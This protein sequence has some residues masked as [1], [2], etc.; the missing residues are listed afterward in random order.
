MAWFHQPRAQILRFY[1]LCLVHLLTQNLVWAYQKFLSIRNFSTILKMFLVYSKVGFYYIN[2]T[3]WVYLK[4]FDYTLKLVYNFKDW[5]CILKANFGSGDKL[6]IRRHASVLCGYYLTNIWALFSEL[7][8]I[9]ACTLYTC[10]HWRMK[11]RL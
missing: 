7:S 3:I 2:W 4:H 1:S 5:I 8:S 11:N 6:G 9:Y 10:M